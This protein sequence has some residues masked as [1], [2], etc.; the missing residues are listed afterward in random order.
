M[1]LKAHVVLSPDG[2]DYFLAPKGTINV[3]Q[4]PTLFIPTDLVFH[5][6]SC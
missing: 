3:G 5:A 4:K 6:V 1:C 2:H